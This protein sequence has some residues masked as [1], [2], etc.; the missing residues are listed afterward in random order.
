MV[1]TSI[2]EGI[3][4]PEEELFEQAHVLENFVGGE[5]DVG[6]RRLFLGLKAEF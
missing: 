3:I 1:P 4:V 6:Q 5:F 2:K